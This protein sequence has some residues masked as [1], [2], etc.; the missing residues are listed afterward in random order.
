MKDCLPKLLV[1]HIWQVLGVICSFS[2]VITDCIH[3]LWTTPEEEAS[4][5]TS[6]LNVKKTNILASPVMLLKSSSMVHSVVVGQKIF[7]G[8]MLGHAVRC[9]SCV[10]IYTCLRVRK[11]THRTLESK[12]NLYL[13]LQCHA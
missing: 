10:C 1:R 4:G 2:S 11:R 7:E 12:D 8:V 3:Q 13:Y 5:S 6:G 9:S